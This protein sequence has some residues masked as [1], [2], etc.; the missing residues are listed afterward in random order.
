[1]RQ[2]RQT[3]ERTVLMS[4]RRVLSVEDFT[5][6]AAMESPGTVKDPLPPGAA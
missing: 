6:A 3:I 2:L 5:A 1:V 4:S